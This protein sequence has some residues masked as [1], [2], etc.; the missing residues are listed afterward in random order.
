LD[1][2]T[3]NLMLKMDPSNPASGAPFALDFNALRVTMSSST[4]TG[5]LAM[6]DVYLNGLKLNMPQP[7]V[8]G[9]SRNVLITGWKLNQGFVITG[10]VAMSWTG[11]QPTN[12]NL[13]YN[14]T[15]GKTATPCVADDCK[16]QNYIISRTWIAED[17]CKNTVAT[18]QIINV[19]DTKSPILVGVPSN[20]TLECGA[21]PSVANVTATDNCDPTPTVTYLGEVSTQTTNGTCTDRNYTLTRSWTVVDNCGNTATSAQV[22]TVIAA[23][24]VNITPSTDAICEGG[25]ASLTSVLDCQ[26]GTTQTYQWQKSEDGS[27]WANVASGGTSANY[28]ASGLTTTTFFRLVVRQGACTAYSDLEVINVTPTPSVLVAVD[29]ATICEGG[30]GVLT[31][32]V[33]GGVGSTTYQWQESNNG[34]T[35][36]ANINLANGSTYSTA[37]LNATRYYRV[38]ITQ[39]GAGCTQTSTAT[40]VNVVKDPTV[41]TQPLGFTE[42]IG[43]TLQLSAVAT[44][45]TPTLMYQWERSANGVSGWTDIAAATTITYTPNS[46]ATGTFYYRLRV[47][48]AGFDCATVYS[49][50]VTVIIA[51]DPEVQVT[52]PSTTVC[53]DGRVILTANPTGGT[54]TCTVQWQSKLDTSNTWLDVPGA[55]GN[56]YQTNTLQATSNYRAVMSCSGNGCCN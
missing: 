20:S 27:N 37:I 1:N 13:N 35:G 16:Q 25:M 30:V 14:I 49:N 33:T 7:S 3:T 21:I 56:T 24:L 19:R 12:S 42:C 15:V 2:D 47:S 40:A 10:R 51:P 4:A 53:T 8:T 22:I 52:V 11:T 5:T 39:T 31:A 45:G 29:N 23:P 50:P 26:A 9:A 32:T 36:W 54:G 38:V 34:A 17:G 41:S 55:T 6:D 43:G 18:T 28:T 48:A 44:G 46:T